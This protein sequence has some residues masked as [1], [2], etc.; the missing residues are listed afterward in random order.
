MC[1]ERNE[2]L[3]FCLRILTVVLTLELLHIIRSVRLVSAL[4][5]TRGRLWWRHWRHVHHGWHT[6]GGTV[7]GHGYTRVHRAGQRD[8]GHLTG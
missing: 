3:R 4:V 5:T 2:P 6:W 7:H 1:T 8:W